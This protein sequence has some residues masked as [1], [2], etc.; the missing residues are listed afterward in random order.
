MS[1]E[2]D[3]EWLEPPELAKEIHVPAATLNQWRYRG[4]GP[5]YAKVGRHIRYRRRDV[6]RWLAGQTVHPRAASQ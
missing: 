2:P 5:A 4:V 1:M 3:D 6:D